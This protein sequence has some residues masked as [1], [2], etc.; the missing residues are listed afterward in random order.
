MD[1]DIEKVEPLHY[2]NSDM[3]LLTLRILLEGFYRG[4]TVFTLDQFLKGEYWKIG[5]L[6]RMSMTKNI[7]SMLTNSSS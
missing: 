1:E 6:L 2:F 4:Q 7:K 3:N 5:E